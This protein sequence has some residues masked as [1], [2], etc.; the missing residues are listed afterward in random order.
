MSRS[1][2]TGYTGRIGL[3]EV[4]PVSDRFRSGILE[5]QTSEQLKQ[6]ALADGLKTIRR[7]GLDKIKQELTTMEEVVSVSTED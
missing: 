1:H 5:R 3:F 7:S 4:L 2:G 6:Q